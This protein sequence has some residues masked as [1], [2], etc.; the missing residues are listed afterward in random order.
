MS[1]KHS[2]G[3]EDGICDDCHNTV[4]HFGTAK[5]TDSAVNHELRKYTDKVRELTIIQILSN[6]ERKNMTSIS[7]VQLRKVLDR[8]QEE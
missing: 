6:M 4:F 3:H 8:L 7:Y 2:C 1:Q 5:T